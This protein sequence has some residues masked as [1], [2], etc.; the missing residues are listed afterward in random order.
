MVPFDVSKL[1]VLVNDLVGGVVACVGALVGIH[2]IPITMQML[3]KLCSRCEMHSLSSL[4][5]YGA[6]GMRDMM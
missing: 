6:R 5:I 2:T 1:V 3:L 4:P